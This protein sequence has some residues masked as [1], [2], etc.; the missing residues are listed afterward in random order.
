MHCDVNLKDT[1][2]QSKK[3]ATVLSIDHHL[4]SISLRGAN[5]SDGIAIEGSPPPPLP[6]PLVF[7]TIAPCT[8]SS[9]SVHFSKAA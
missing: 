9:A 3:V 2:T 4:P 5:G 6:C 7:P 8:D 1:K